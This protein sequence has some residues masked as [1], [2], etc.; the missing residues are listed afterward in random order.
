[1]KR[2]VPVFLV[3]LMIGVSRVW[4]D[5]LCGD[6]IMSCV[7]SPPGSAAG[8][9]APPKPKLKIIE[10]VCALHGCISGEIPSNCTVVGGCQDIECTEVDPDSFSIDLLESYTIIED[11]GDYQLIEDSEGK[12]C[13]L[14][15]CQE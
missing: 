14:T 8:A 13:A 10:C 4:A 1:M 3:F 9:P 7:Q 15:P 12:L 2:L 6:G 5:E 11:F